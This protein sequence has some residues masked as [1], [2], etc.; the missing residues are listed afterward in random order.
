MAAAELGL[1]QSRA[2][3]DPAEDLLDALA[4][5]LA[6]AVTGMA[7]RAPI[8]PGLAPLAGLG[9]VVLDRDMGGHFAVPQLLDKVCNVKTLVPSQ[10]DP[11]LASSTLHGGDAYRSDQGRLRV[12]PCRW[13]A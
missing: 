8:D 3:L 1:A 10:R 6:G 2:R 9:E 4:A 12:P 11:P 5:T 7:R 13:P